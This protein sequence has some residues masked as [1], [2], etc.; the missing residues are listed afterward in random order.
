MYKLA[1]SRYS[2]NM[3]NF[4][5]TVPLEIYF[6]A[7]IVVITL[8]FGIPAIIASGKLKP[9]PD[10]IPVP[11]MIVNLYNLYQRNLEITDPRHHKE[12]ISTDQEFVRKN[13]IL[14]R[15]KRSNNVAEDWFYNSDLYPT[16]R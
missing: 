8:A 13:H 9:A 14:I 2:L 7:A 1:I 16:A 5:T 12:P 10:M 15:R 11:A 6:I 3:I 4:L